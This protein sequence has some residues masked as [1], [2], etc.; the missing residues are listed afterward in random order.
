ML[1]LGCI[2]FRGKCSKHPH[3][4]PHDGRGAIK[5]GCQT[6]EKLLDILAFHTRMLARMREFSPPKEMKR[7]RP[8]D[9]GQM[10]L[11]TEPQEDSE[12]VRVAERL[13]IRKVDTE[14]AEAV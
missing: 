2:R 6:C 3:F 7:Y 8:E 12:A 1:K 4:D 11:F 14:E 10:G 5:G 13:R 9:D